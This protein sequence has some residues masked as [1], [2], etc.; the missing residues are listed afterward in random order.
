MCLKRELQYYRRSSSLGPVKTQDT[1]CLILLCRYDVIPQS[2][3]HLVLLIDNKLGMHTKLSI[4][5]ASYPLIVCNKCLRIF[6]KCVKLRQSQKQKKREKVA[7]PRGFNFI[8]S[9]YIQKVFSYKFMNFR[10]H[11]EGFGIVATV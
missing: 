3:L 2:F 9:T 10:V 5:K 8:C 7:L 1:A 11:N 4:R 6:M